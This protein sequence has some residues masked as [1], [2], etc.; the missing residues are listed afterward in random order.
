MPPS[1]IEAVGE[2]L[3]H[4]RGVRAL[5][6]RA[7]LGQH[8]AHERVEQYLLEPERGLV[9]LL[10]VVRAGAHGGGQRG[11]GHL[12][13]A[14]DRSSAL[15][16]VGDAHHLVGRRDG[17]RGE[18]VRRAATRSSATIASAMSVFEASS[19]P[20]VST[21]ARGAATAAP[22]A[23]GG[24]EGVVADRQQAGLASARSRASRRP[25]RRPAAVTVPSGP[26]AISSSAV[27]V[28]ILIA[29]WTS[30]PVLVVRLP[31]PSMCRLP[32]RVS[33]SRPSGRRMRRKPSPWIATSSGRSVR[34]SDALRERAARV[35]G[36]GAGAGADALGRRAAGL[37]VDKVAETD[38]LVLVARRVRVR[39]VVGDGVEALLLGCH[40]GGRG[41]KSFDHSPR[42][43]A[44]RPET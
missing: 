33:A 41:V 40:A 2:G 37:V 20:C 18:L 36:G 22:E 13:E 31:A 28:G 5:G 14:V 39:Q 27:P 11:R 6:E 29:G 35:D 10:V 21:V 17:L 43:S 24:D 9:G 3:L 16:L 26:I 7:V 32:S 44:N 8:L 12:R 30:E 23:G 34:C 15:H 25:M 19:A 1:A 38:A 4:R 42:S